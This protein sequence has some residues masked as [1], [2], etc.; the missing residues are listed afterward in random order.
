MKPLEDETVTI[1]VM[2]ITPV[3]KEKRRIGCANLSNLTQKAS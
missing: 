3:K 2:H 1:I